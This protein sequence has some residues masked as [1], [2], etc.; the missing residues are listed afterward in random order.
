MWGSRLSSGPCL[1]WVDTLACTK[2]TCH[3]EI[4]GVHVNVQMASDGISLGETVKSIVCG[5]SLESVLSMPKKASI[6]CQTS[7]L[8]RETLGLH[9]SIDL[10]AQA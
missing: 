6:A 1:K 2:P 10:H 5:A 7:A 4:L 3:W 8:S 9:E